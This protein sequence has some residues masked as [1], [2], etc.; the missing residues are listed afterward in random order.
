VRSRSSKTAISYSW[1]RKRHG[2]E[3]RPVLLSRPMSRVHIAVHLMRGYLV[4]V[5]LTTAIYVICFR[6][7]K[8]RAFSEAE[9]RPMGRTAG[10][11][12]MRLGTAQRV[13]SRLSRRTNVWRADARTRVWQAHAIAGT[14]ATP[15]HPGD[16]AIHAAS[17]TGAAAGSLSV[18]KTRSCH[19]D[20][21][22]LIR[23]HVSGNRGRADPRGR[24][25]HH[26]GENEKLAGSRRSS[27]RRRRC[28][29]AS[30]YRRTEFRLAASASHRTSATFR[31]GDPTWREF[32]ISA[33]ARQCCRAGSRQAA[34]EMLDW[35][36][37]GLSVMEMSHRARIHRVHAQA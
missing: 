5:A 36:G 20:G 33:Q 34:A 1:R 19:H 32:S 25:S 35:H 24:A 22:V 6:R 7:R 11:W 18:T 10:A 8:G 2:Q 12:R 21:G 30:A 9:L 17:A 3:D 16:D 29:A 28:G 13:I 27:S 23:T 14:R 4:G 15:R 31:I 26:L 37:C